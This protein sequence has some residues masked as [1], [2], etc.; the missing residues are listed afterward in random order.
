M[1]Q[2]DLMFVQ[3]GVR[4][5]KHKEQA[6]ILEN[7]HGVIYRCTFRINND[8]NDRIQ[9]I[10]AHPL[11]IDRNGGCSNLTFFSCAEL[12]FVRICNTT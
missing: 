7:I 8:Q 3:I 11:L 12:G 1:L 10:F 2:S 5:K 4:N 6:L 9:F